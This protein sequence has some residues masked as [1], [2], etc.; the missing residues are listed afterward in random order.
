MGFDV[1]PFF[2]QLPGVLDMLIL[3]HRYV[4][5]WVRVFYATLY[6]EHDRER[7]QFM[8]QGWIYRFTRAKVAELLE[9]QLHDT[10]LHSVVYGQLGPPRR[11]QQGGT[12]PSLEDVTPVFAPRFTARVTSQLRPLAAVLYRIIG[13]TLLPRAGAR[14]SVTSL[15]QRV[16][17]T[18]VCREQFCVVDFMIAEM[19]D[20]ITMGFKANTTVLPYA[21]YISYMLSRIGA[22]DNIPGP[23]YD[24][25]RAAPSFPNCRAQV[26]PDP[27][28]P[29]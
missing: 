16:L 24:I 20:A 2:S 18:L 8:F 28:I 22:V 14:E 23:Y 25:Y 17:A 1:E 19:E 21:S 7:I 27:C 11:A 10:R 3:R 12:T 4:E 29:A 9:L 6:I 26:P 5:E 13:H 15:Q